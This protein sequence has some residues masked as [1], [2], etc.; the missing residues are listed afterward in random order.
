M[1][2]YNKGKQHI[3]PV[4]TGGE[5]IRGT[6]KRPDDDWFSLASD[7]PLSLLL[8]VKGEVMQYG[9]LR[10]GLQLCFTQSA[11]IY[12]RVHCYYLVLFYSS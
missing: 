6:E 5:I 7:S 8:R 12:S 11:M 4:R 2:N 9:V 3:Q 1:A 10:T